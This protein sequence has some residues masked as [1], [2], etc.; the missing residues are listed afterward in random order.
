MGDEETIDDVMQ[1]VQDATG[2]LL[3]MLMDNA[4][5]LTPKYA[6][7]ARRA[8]DEFQKVGFDEETALQLTLT[9]LGNMGKSK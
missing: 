2:P 9:V 5:R 7:L 1:K 6:T 8:F 4:I 3:D